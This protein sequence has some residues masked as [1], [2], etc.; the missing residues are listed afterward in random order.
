MDVEDFT[1]ENSF[2]KSF[3]TIVRRQLDPVWH[4]V[5]PATKQLV[6]DLGVLQELLNYL[7]QYDCVSFYSF[8]ET[9]IASNTSKDGRQVRQSQWLFLD[10]ADK[11]ISVCATFFR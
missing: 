6:S 9:I 11:A 2:F 4:R 8:I 1:I 5:S 7:T 10:A 3:H